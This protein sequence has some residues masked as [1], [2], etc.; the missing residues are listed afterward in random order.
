[1]TEDKTS[2]ACWKVTLL[3][4]GLWSLLANVP[5]ATASNCRQPEG[6]C[7]FGVFPH[8]STRQIATT[9]QTI[10]EELS[11]V[12][13]R[14]VRLQTARSIPEFLKRLRQHRY[15]IALAGIGHYLM[16]A[17]PAGYIP[18]AH[19]ENPLHYVLVTPQESPLRDIDDLR[20][21]RLGLMPPQNGTS[22][23]GQLILRDHGLDPQKDL[24]VVRLGSQQGCI[25]AML[26]AQVDACAIAEPVVETF[27][28]MMNRHFRIL[29]RS[30]DLPNVSYLAS[31]LLAPDQIEALRDYF[32]DREHFVAARPSHYSHFRKRIEALGRP[33]EARR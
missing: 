22:I 6:T 28:A 29:A 1:M 11:L 10:A 23:A 2:R 15:D 27:E 25:H 13:D 16:V 9:Y 7:I 32:S 31:P 3:W 30:E 17:E 26:T 19:R 4:L 8:S 5:P 33:P 12:L 21:R 24:T 18:L 20:G 14:D